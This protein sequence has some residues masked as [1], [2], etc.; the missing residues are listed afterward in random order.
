M[1]KILLIDLSSAYFPV[2]VEYR[3]LFSLRLKAQDVIREQWNPNLRQ[4]GS[5][6]YSRGLLSI[7]ASLEQ[8]GHQ[9]TY[10]HC[11]YDRICMSSTVL[12]DVDIVGITCVTPTFP[13]A[14]DVLRIIKDIDSNIITV[15]GGSHVTYLAEDILIKFF[16]L[17]DIIVRGEGEFAITEIANHPHN[18]VDIAG[19]T[20]F[21]DDYSERQVVVRN[22]D[23]RLCDLDRLLRPSYHLLPFSLSHYS[24]NLMATR[25]CLFRCPYCI[26]GRYFSGLRF[27]SVEQVIDELTY[28]AE[29]VPPGT[30]IHFCDS[31]F[32][33]G[34]ESITN[35]LKSITAMNFGLKYSCDLRI[36]TITET[37]INAMREAGFIQY[38]LGIESGD[39]T[40]LARHKQ[41][42]K[43]Q[44]SIDACKIIREVDEQA[45]IKAYWIAGLPGTTIQ[46]LQQDAEVIGFLIWE[47]IV[48]LIGNKIL[49][50]YPGTPMFSNSEHFGLS[51][52]HRDWSKYLRSS[53]PVY[54]LETIS[55]SDLFEGFLMQE[56]I[57]LDAYCGVLGIDKTDLEK[58]EPND[59][60]YRQFFNSPLME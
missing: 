51:I 14:I 37:S 12:Q 22:P 41:N 20:F 9:V 7:G 40:L 58:V 15:L 11:G 19:I 53:M 27:H 54:D 36:S 42:Q 34:K 32:N 25:G 29:R 24:L 52:L 31:V 28:I 44:E 4:R 39:N 35:L 45:F 6:T 57:L 1:T 46:S 26:D 8:A 43:L 13:I 47:N 3:D 59:Y 50:P 56:E 23:R 60:L 18:L 33:T 5:V 48:N 55:S 21:S 49:V 10:V 30:L 2:P 17:V 16:P 38:C